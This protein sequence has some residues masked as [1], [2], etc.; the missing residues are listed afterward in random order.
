SDIGLRDILV[1]NTDTGE[2][3]R[4]EE[5][6]EKLDKEI[7]YSVNA[8]YGIIAATSY[9]IKEYIG[10]NSYNY[11]TACS[12]GIKHVVQAIISKIAIML[13]GIAA[14][15]VV[16]LIANLILRGDNI[17][18]KGIAAIITGILLL[19]II[20]MS[21]LIPQFQDRLTESFF[22]RA[23]LASDV[24]AGQLPK[25]SFLNLREADD[26]MNDDYK[27]IKK[28]ATNVFYNE[29]DSMKDLYCC[30]Y[31]IVDGAFVMSY[32]LKDSVGAI[33]PY[34]WDLEGSTEEQVLTTKQGVRYQSTTSEGGEYLF[35]YNPIIDDDGNAIGIIEVGKDMQSYRYEMNNMIRDA[36]IN[37]FAV[38]AVLILTIIEVIYFI[39]GR[40]DYLE[41]AS[42][43]GGAR[44]L[45][46]E[47][48]RMASF[49][50]YFL[51]NLATA[52]LPIY[53]MRIAEEGGS[54]IAPEV[55]AAI[56]LSAEV[57]TGAIFSIVGV[58][59][60]EKMGEK[61]ALF[62]SSI[63]FT[64][65]FVLRIIPNIWI[66]ILGNGVLGIGWGVILLNAN[67][68]IS[69]LPDDQKELGFSQFNA[70]A[71]NGVNCGVVF[72]GFLI[73]WVNY[74]M[75]F[76]I[77]AL[78]SL[79]MLFLT[80]KYFINEKVA[81]ATEAKQNG[82]EQIRKTVAFL[83]NARVWTLF[84]LIV[85]PILICTY[86]INYM[87]PI[88]GS[89]YGLSDTYVGYSYLLNGLCVVA[90]GGVITNYFTKKNKKREGLVAA[91]LIYALA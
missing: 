37:V 70:A 16:L 22:S 60:I 26:F 47:I 86:F 32:S 23:Q 20:I 14:L 29:A 66:L 15:Y 46:P 38:A 3:E 31:Q 13:C 41:K 40:N 54:L 25:D 5:G 30:L 59:M 24:M 83:L 82:T 85:A 11:L 21:V 52:F 36:I 76:V 2:I 57:I 34:D 27:A 42:D 79:T 33:Y 28:V 1:I 53:A 84:L 6:G 12:L 65:G 73:N 88:I 69:E 9:S 74:Q 67:L 72:G 90:F 39:K 78:L 63:L 55:M 7:A 48:M 35:T 77:S 50:V 51:T 4:I 17:Y 81:E 18:V 43:E 10:D 49:L 89:D 68:H 58:S 19:T 62:V 61:K 8:D 87:Y 71:M 64:I 75:L 91:S 80:G 56:P 44:V 45:P